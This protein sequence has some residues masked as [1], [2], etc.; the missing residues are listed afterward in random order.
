MAGGKFVGWLLDGIPNL[1]NWIGKKRRV[2]EVDKIDN[3]IAGGNDKSIGDVLKK[4]IKKED[5]RK[6]ANS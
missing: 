5:T 2:H 3:A 6:K 1:V 4:I